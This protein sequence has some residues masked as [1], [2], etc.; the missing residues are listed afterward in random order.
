M[1]RLEKRI[2]IPETCEKGDGSVLLI[3]FC[4]AEL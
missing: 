1:I 2:L 4:V 3:F